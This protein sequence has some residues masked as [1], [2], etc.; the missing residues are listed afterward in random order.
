MKGDGRDE[1]RGRGGRGGE[2][3]RE[4]IEKNI[5][6]KKEIATKAPTLVPSGSK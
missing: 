6:E 3:R 1:E 4:T 2:V 5:K